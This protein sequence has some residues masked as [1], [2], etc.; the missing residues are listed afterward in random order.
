MSTIEDATEAAPSE[1][2]TD[3]VYAWAAVGDA[4]QIEPL[5]EAAE[6]D[7]PADD[8]A[9]AP[10]QWR[11]RLTWAA[12]VAAVISTA[13]AVAWLGLALYRDEHVPPQQAVAQAAAAPAPAPVPAPTRVLPPP[14]APA[15]PTPGPAAAHE[16]PPPAAPPKPAPSAPPLMPYDTPDDAVALG[17]E[18]CSE[19][20]QW[21]SRGPV[22]NNIVSP[23]ATA[24]RAQ[25]EAQVDAAEKNFCPWNQG[26]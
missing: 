15:A 4:A 5:D 7:A 18:L 9:S 3:L 24:T 17:T 10:G 6:G 1:D 19:L 23:P 16:T 13:A 8:S 21:G 26:K 22:V 2:N 14:P 12:L 11:D 25:A 20:D